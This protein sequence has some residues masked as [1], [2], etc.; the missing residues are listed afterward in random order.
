MEIGQRNYEILPESNGKTL[1]C[2][3]TRYFD[4]TNK[5]IFYTR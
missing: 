4:Q 1:F 5:K 2:H 3:T